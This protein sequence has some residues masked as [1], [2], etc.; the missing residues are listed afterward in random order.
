MG[1]S[2][3]LRVFAVP[4]APIIHTL[5]QSDG[6]TFKARQW[7]D[8][9][10]HGWETLDGYSIV[11]D[12]SVKSWAYAVHDSFGRLISSLRIVGRESLPDGLNK[13]LRPTSHA[14]SIV[15]KKRLSK[16]LLAENPQDLIPTTGV[17][18]IPVILINFSDR[19]T[20]Y[21]TGD[22]TT[23]LFG[24]GK[25]SM[26]DY[27]EEVSYDTFSI[28]AGSNGVVGWYQASNTHDYY[29]QNGTS[30]EDMWP[31]DLVYEAVAQ[32]DA[33]GFNFAP[34]DQDGDGYVDVVAIVHQGTGEEV[35]G[36][37]TDISS[38]SWNLNKAQY[39]GASHFGEYTTNDPRP[40]GGYIKINNY[41]IMP[42]TFSF[43]G[44]LTTIGVFAHEYGHALCLPDLYDTDYSSQG[45]G[46]WSLMA[47]G[48]WNS[49]TK[50][51]DSPAHMDA[52]CKYKLGWV[53][54][55]QVSGTLT[56]ELIDQ[57]ATTADMYQLLSGSPST[58]GE[59]FLV[60]NRQKTGFDQGLPGAGLLI[61]HI[62]E[63]MGTNSN[64]CYPGI[65]FCSSLHY[66]VALE[67]ADN[68]WELERNFN[69]GDTGDPYPGTTNNRSFTESSS[70]D[71]NLYNGSPSSVSITNISDSGSVMTAT[72]STP[73]I[74]TYSIS[75]ESQSF[76][77]SGGTGSISVSTQSSCT[78]TATSN[79]SWITI[80]SGSSGT[81]N[82]TV[83]YSVSSNT[84]TSQRV[85]T[86]TI[87]GQTFTVTQE[88]MI[89]YSVSGTVILNGSGLSGVTVTLSGPSSGNTI[90]DYSG[91]YSFTG[92]TDGTY[93]VTPS[94]SGYTFT[95][96]SKSVTISGAN[97]TG[98]NFTASAIPGCSPP[99]DVNQDGKVNTGD[100][101][102]VIDAILGNG[103]S[104]SC[105]DVN[106]DGK[107]STSDLTPIIDYIL[108]H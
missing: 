106:R 36:L 35:S 73:T 96:T 50:S 52:W 90:T 63:S 16:E 92:L 30:D 77:S 105:L 44:D 84:T 27:F 72:L 76:E 91:N 66:H 85:G 80:T 47:N 32:A 7:G 34:Y 18:T 12:E 15:P 25:D 64:E 99:E 6:S 107:V 37:P 22:F 5:S 68:L 55:T 2:L 54:P 60:E 45:I 67:Q 13:Y 78:W 103:Q 87:Y 39:F 70:P 69:S 65:P 98:Q 23:L 53:T 17:A 81:G 100:L 61:W 8:E 86:M 51:G 20:T 33:N 74:C 101:T 82:G 19:T 93:S 71:S 40:G 43:L 102:P 10:L 4:A 104:S 97:K 58:G 14:R 46:R 79:A 56:N 88:G 83:K 57:S 29:G 9:S 75:P 48:S 59:Y 42:E 26:R 41:I 95:P 89:T 1:V 28:S 21:K 38:H 31:G 49:V 94:K 11:F 62:D 24:T 108:S 3:P